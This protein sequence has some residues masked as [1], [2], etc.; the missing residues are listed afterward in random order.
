MSDEA[1]VGAESVESQES[2]D[3]GEVD[4]ESRLKAMETEL[5]ERKKSEAGL[6]RAISETKKEN[7]QLQREVEEKA[8]AAMDDTQRLV[9]E[10]EAAEKKAA[11]SD[12]RYE[13]MQRT[14]MIS[15]GVAQNKLD[16]SVTKLMRV[17]TTLEERDD[18]FA[19]YKALQEPYVATTVNE[20]LAGA[21]TPK[22]NGTKATVD[23]QGKSGADMSEEEFVAYSVDVLQE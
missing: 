5:A 1:N 9:Y 8:K 12:A 23:Y 15:D 14:S 3:S 16:P 2:Q 10:K 21:P 19:T 7:E 6:H 11:E 18:W 17:P 4:F 22:V 20:R 13:E